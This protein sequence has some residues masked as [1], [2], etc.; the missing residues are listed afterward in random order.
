[1]RSSVRSRT[2]QLRFLEFKIKIRN[3]IMEHLNETL[4][5]IGSMVGFQAAIEL[6]GL[7]TLQDVEDAK[8]DLQ[9]GQQSMTDLVRFTI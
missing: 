8:S 2:S 9:A 4:A 6:T 5:K 1:L 7:P 3:L